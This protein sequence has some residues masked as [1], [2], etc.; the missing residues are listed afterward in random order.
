MTETKTYSLQKQ[1]QKQKQKNKTK[2][3]PQS[4][5]IK[6]KIWLRE[7]QFKIHLMSKKI[8]LSLALMT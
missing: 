2:Y 7:T 8:I 6:K 5:F 4:S 1:N 3:S